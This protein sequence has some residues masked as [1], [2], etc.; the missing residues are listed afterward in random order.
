MKQ[1]QFIPLLGC[2]G[3]SPNHYQSLSGMLLEKKMNILNGSS[4]ELKCAAQFMERGFQVSFP[5]G[6]CSRYDFI[7]DAY[8]VLYRFQCKSSS[9]VKSGAYLMRTASSHLMCGMTKAKIRAYTKEQIDFFCT[10]IGE[11]CYVIPIEFCEGMKAV[12]MM[13]GECKRFQ[14]IDSASCLLDNVFMEDHLEMPRINERQKIEKQKRVPKTIQADDEQLRKEFLE[15]SI[16]DMSKK[17]NCSRRFVVKELKKRGIYDE[18]RNKHNINTIH[19]KSIAER[20][21]VV[22][23]DKYGNVIREYDGASQAEP[24]GFKRNV[25]QMCC[26]GYKKS[27]KGFLWY[28]K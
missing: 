23:C 3:A 21:R 12:S 17:Y 27:Y 24:F 11:D 9:K 4:I 15:C 2:L 5:Y 18:L 16:Y 26:N 10:I 7:V 25:I 19:R 1:N 20:K 8:G 14:R 13:V 6:N 22:Q 28:Y